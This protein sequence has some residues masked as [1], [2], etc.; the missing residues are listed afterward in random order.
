MISH[1]DLRMMDRA[2][3]L[4]EHGMGWTSPNPMVGAVVVVGG[5]IVAE[6]F[7]EKFGERHA[8]PIALDKAGNRAHGATLYVNLEP[9]AHQ[10]KTPPCL[11]RVIN[12]DVA[13]VVIGMEDPNP[14][15]NGK[16]IAALRERGIEVE[17]GVR[18]QEARILNRPFISRITRNRPW[19]TAKYAMTLDGRI[20]TSAGQSKW[21]SGT[22]ARAFVHELRRRNRAILVGFRTAMSDNPLLTCRLEATRPIRQPLRVVVGGAGPLPPNSR[23]VSSSDEVETLHI[24]S[25][26]R[27]KQPV[28][29]HGSVEAAVMGADPQKTILDELM[30]N[31]VDRGIDSVLVE[32]GAQT[33]AHLLE[34]GWVD[35][36]YAFVSP[37]LLNDSEALPPFPGRQQPENIDE[38][39]RLKRVE[40]KSFGEDVLIHGFISDL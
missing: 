34:E 21:I 1:L 7:H 16:S 26:K 24:L 17:V 20:A 4:A 19:V 36:I 18:E 8:E 6:G 9:C 23:L 14:L 22:P 32:G 11:N 29:E 27:W 37:V 12:S 2:L 39:L 13:R 15:T 28:Q 31:L 33:L 35:E 3:E 10:G 5:E 30:G 25:S 40:I 38:A